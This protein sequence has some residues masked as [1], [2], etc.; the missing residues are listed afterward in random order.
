MEKSLYKKNEIVFQI[1]KAFSNF[2]CENVT[3]NRTR[4]FLIE[5][6]ST[7]QKK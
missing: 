1:T 5:A 4:P 7:T 3:Q 2:T 6:K